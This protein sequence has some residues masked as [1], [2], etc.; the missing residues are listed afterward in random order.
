MAGADSLRDLSMFL[1]GIP[2]FAPLG[3]A[4]RLEIAGHLEPL[5]VPAG[6]VLF[7]QGDTGDGLYLV[8]SGRLRVTAEAD[9][10]ARMLYDLGR[11]AIV[12]E[13]ALLTNRPRAAT[14][15]AVRDSDLRVL[16]VAAF[17]GRGPRARAGPH[18]RVLR[19]GE[20]LPV[21]LVPAAARAGALIGAA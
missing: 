5:H 3:E 9:G 14:V 1:D 8:A 6:E 21:G 4:T 18:G 20:G 17:S 16:R 19:G 15:H 2:F 11:G 13:M 12:G 10:Y 7:R